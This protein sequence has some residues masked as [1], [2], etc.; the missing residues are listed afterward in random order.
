MDGETE[1]TGTAAL[2]KRSIVRRIR[3]QAEKPHPKIMKATPARR[4]P[5]RAQSGESVMLSLFFATPSLMR[6]AAVKGTKCASVVQ[7][8][9]GRIIAHQVR[10]SIVA[11]ERVVIKT[12]S[13]ATQATQS[14]LYPC[15]P[16]EVIQGTLFASE[17]RQQ[18]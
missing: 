14:D 8:R 1:K 6:L 3:S 17:V 2:E 16:A 9:T 11:R 7:L 12:R 5:I 15:Y 13:D 10:Q 4:P 18:T